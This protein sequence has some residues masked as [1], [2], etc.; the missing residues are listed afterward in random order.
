MAVLNIECSSQT[1]QP[2]WSSLKNYQVPKWYQDAKFGIFIHWGVYSVPAFE[3]EWYPREMYMEGTEA[4]KHHLETYGSQS[5]FG[6][7]DFIKMFK[8]EKWNPEEWAELFAKSGARFVVEVAEHHD[9]FPMYD[10]SYTT[11][12]AYDMGP[13]RDIVGE[14]EKAI[15]KRGLKFGV[16]S[17]RAFNW[18][19]YPRGNN[20]DTNNP[21]F[22]GLYGIGHKEP[23]AETEE[24][25]GFDYLCTSESFLKDWDARTTELVDKYEPDLIWFDWVINREE[26][27]PYLQKFASYYYNKGIEWNKGVVINYKYDAFPDATAV[28]DVERGKLSGISERTWQTDTSVGKK[29]W[30]YI[31]D[32]EYKSAGNLVDQLIDIVSKNGILLLNIGPKSDGTIPQEAKEILLKI[33]KWLSINGEAIYGTRPWKIYGEGPTVQFEGAHQE[34]KNKSY[35]ADDVRY[36]IGVQDS[37]TPFYAIALDWADTEFHFPSLSSGSTK[38]YK[39][40]NQVKM[41]GYDGE[42]VWSQSKDGL[43]IKSPDK[44]PCEYA[45]CFVIY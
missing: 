2:N 14:L 39:K 18:S 23:N 16:S 31:K 21:F 22:W 34:S 5:E 12:D 19:Y 32:E 45:Y 29:S 38:K 9:G 28:L 26:F 27:E 8:A 40:V 10:C 11:W 4:Y 24:T 35:T 13:Q 42:L 41:L 7:K 25:H 6:Y 1:F 3:S 20:Y 44:K 15:R 43:T 30:G 33:G 36:L 17:H 37:R